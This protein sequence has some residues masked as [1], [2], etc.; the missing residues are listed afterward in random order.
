MTRRNRIVVFD[1]ETTGLPQCSID[2][3]TGE[4]KYYNPC[5]LD[6]YD[7]SRVVQL[8]W[9]CLDEHG[10]NVVSKNSF[11]IRP[12]GF[13]VP[14]ES[15]K[16][17]GISHARAL[18]GGF[19]MKEALAAFAA[20]LKRAHTVVAHNFQFDAHVLSSEAIRYGMPDVPK[21]L[22]GANKFDTMIRSMHYFNLGKKP[23]LTDLYRILFK[24]EV[25]QRHDALDDAMLTAS[26]F[27]DLR[28]HMY[29]SKLRPAVAAA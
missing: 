18:A 26:C 16:I 21:A 28:T 13:T 1:T 29:R 27:S 3:I 20:D 17:H 6:K 14:E 12:D 9:V 22:V 8:A 2:L 19:P 24:R 7:T 15:T 5:L 11:L 4:R 10:Q 23:K 25:V